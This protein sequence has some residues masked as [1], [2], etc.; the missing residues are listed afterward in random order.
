MTSTSRW[1]LVLPLLFSVCI[2][3]TPLFA[4]SFQKG[5]V[6]GELT[7]YL[8]ANVTVP[9]R[10]NTPHEDPSGRLYLEG[11]LD[12]GEYTTDACVLDRMRYQAARVTTLEVGVG[13]LKE[14]LAAHLTRTGYPRLP[15]QVDAA[16]RDRQITL[17]GEIHNLDQPIQEA[18]GHHASTILAEVAAAW[19]DREEYDRIIICGG[20]AY[21]FGALVKQ[22]WGDVAQ[23]VP[24]PEWANVL[25]FAAYLGWSQR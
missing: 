4:L 18:A 21:Y 1:A 16:L 10:R 12:I 9:L 15:Y 23:I 14:A 25:G 3:P 6:F 7:G 20:G 2:A 8:E 17:G 19:P 13:K 22:V 5:E 24:M 11:V